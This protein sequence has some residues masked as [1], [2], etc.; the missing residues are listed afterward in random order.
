VLVTGRIWATVEDGDRRATTEDGDQQVM[1]EGGDQRAMT[2]DGDRQRC[3]HTM[4]EFQFGSTLDLDLDRTR[5][6]I[7]L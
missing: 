6:P 3:W 2:E 4:L 5:H 1:A 7:E